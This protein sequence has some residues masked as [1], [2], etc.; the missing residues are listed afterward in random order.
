MTIAEEAI[1]N[2]R[3]LEVPH[4]TSGASKFLTVSVG[5]AT[6]RGRLESSEADLIKAA[7]RMLYQAK[8]NGRNCIFIHDGDEAS[9]SS[10][11]ILSEEILDV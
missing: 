11:S 6:V 1:E 2:I 4:L 7:D 5:I 3:K 9:S 10:M 8:Q